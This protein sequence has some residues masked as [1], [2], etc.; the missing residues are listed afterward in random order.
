MSKAVKAEGETQCIFRLTETGGKEQLL[1]SAK[2][3]RVIKWINI[4]S[5]VS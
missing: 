5:M 4:I 1:R 2:I 3:D